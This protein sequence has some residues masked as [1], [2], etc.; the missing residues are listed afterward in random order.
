M[1]MNLVRAADR[2]NV[3]GLIVKEHRADTLVTGDLVV[4]RNHH[5]IDT[6]LGYHVAR[7]ASVELVVNEDDYDGE[8]VIL[9]AVPVGWGEEAYGY[10]GP[11]WASVTRF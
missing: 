2:P 5:D 3:G 10:D 9:W 1:L 8:R 11:R 6:P 4:L 7:V